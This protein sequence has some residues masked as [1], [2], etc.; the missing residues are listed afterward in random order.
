[1]ENGLTDGAAAG[2]GAAAAAAGAS[3]PS[4]FSCGATTGGCEIE[5]EFGARRLV[6]RAVS[7]IM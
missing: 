2:A 7:A 3:S 6:T 5:P 4:F 1:M